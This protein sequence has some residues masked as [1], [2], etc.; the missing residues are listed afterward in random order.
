[1]QAG[2]RVSLKS[3]RGCRR[4]ASPDSSTGVDACRPVCGLP[5]LPWDGLAGPGGRR[6]GA[7][8]S[9]RRGGPPALNVG[10]PRPS[11]AAA[12]VAVDVVVSRRRRGR[13][14]RRRRG[15][16]RGTRRG[17]R[18]GRGYPGRRGGPSASNRGQPGPSGAAAGEPDGHSDC[19]WAFEAARPRRTWANVERPAGRK[20]DAPRNVRARWSAGPTRRNGRDLRG[21]G[22]PHRF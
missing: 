6:T 1:M 14:G 10:Q 17:G 7:K 22:R 3:C 20:S 12:G 8:V 4:R 21:R 5:E 19:P 11:G 13:R 2:R 18:R 15:G 9:G 16:R